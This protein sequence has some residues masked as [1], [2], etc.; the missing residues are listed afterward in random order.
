MLVASHGDTWAADAV[1]SHECIRHRS[2]QWTQGVKRESPLAPMSVMGQGEL[3][4]ARPAGA[5]GVKEGNDG[6][7]QE[8]ETVT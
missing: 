5:L 4:L 6:A 7:G 8:S 3:R 1:S 2:V